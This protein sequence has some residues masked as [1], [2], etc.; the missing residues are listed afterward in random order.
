[1]SSSA[2]YAAASSQF[3]YGENTVNLNDDTTLNR[4]VVATGYD[5]NVPL[6]NVVAMERSG[7]RNV[8]YFTERTVSGQN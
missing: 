3:S 1:M 7:T 8:N 2:G 5:V 4:R 6:S